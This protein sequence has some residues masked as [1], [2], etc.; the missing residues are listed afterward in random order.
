MN[1]EKHLH[2]PTKK[3]ITKQQLTTRIAKKLPGLTDKVVGRSVQ[4]I[5]NFIADS[6]LAEN[7]VEV[8]GFG[9]F[10]LRQH[11]SRRA[12]NPRTG[13]EFIAKPKYVL[14]FKPSKDLREQ[15]EQLKG[16]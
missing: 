2:N 1:N 15:L 5:I 7:R 11:A 12:R 3:V 14:R 6:L 10:T 16:K 13:E 4:E 8:R 9:S